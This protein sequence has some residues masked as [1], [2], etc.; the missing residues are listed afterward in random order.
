MALL[1]RP[2]RTVVVLCRGFYTPGRGAGE[3]IS[4]LRSI[5]MLN[6]NRIL[7]LVV[8]LVFGGA[9][10]GYY[11][12]VMSPS[13]GG[14]ITPSLLPAAY[15]HPA[16]LAFED[17]L[18]RGE[19]LSELLHRSQ[20]AEAEASTL[21]AALIEHQDPRRLRPGSVISYRK[22]VAGG[23]LRA[24]ELR[25]DADRT[26]S[27]RRADNGWKGSIEEVPVH[28]DTAVLAGT[29]ESSLYAA[30]VNAGG[31][32][33]PAR[34]REWI[35]DIVADRVFAWQVDF[36]RDLRAGDRFRI[37]YERMVRPNGT[38]RSGRVLGVEF[39]INGRDYEG[40]F[41]ATPDGTEDYYDANGESL[42]RAFLRAPLEYRRISSA[43]STGRFHPILKRTRP[44]HGI[45]YAASSG[46]PI[47]AVGDGVVRR[48]GDAGGYGNLIEIRHQRG[49]STRYAHMKRFARGIRSGVRVK[50]GQVIGYVG[51]TG[52]ATG[53]HL[54]YEF[55]KNGS[56]VNPKTIE[57]I[58]G[59]PVPERYRAQFASL[60]DTHLAVMDARTESI[61]FAEAPTPSPA[62]ADGE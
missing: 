59:D 33:V 12:Q 40:F 2:V 53:P 36:S 16:E 10:A 48:A 23:G 8:F 61:R 26:L 27:L 21:L 6:P 19:T 49:Y 13:R 58:T 24:M 7:A 47:R 32:G 35:V 31:S 28:A 3:T 39:S 43:F 44:H 29:V 50:Q 15:A 4:Q 51:M 20:L 11:L 17:T 57:Q 22:S 30:L 18:R 45:D 46:T 42:R 60:V 34:E 55:R 62:S 1:F 5:S 14:S 25:L 41:F 56:P 9:I 54:H 38:A 37:L 52:L